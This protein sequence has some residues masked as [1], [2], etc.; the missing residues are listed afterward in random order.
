MNLCWKL[1][2]NKVLFYLLQTFLHFFSHARRSDRH[3]EA[4]SLG[5]LKSNDDHGAGRRS[6]WVG[7]FVPPLPVQQ[8]YQLWHRAPPLLVHQQQPHLIG[9]TENK[10]SHIWLAEQRAK[11]ATSNWQNREQ[12]PSFNAAGGWGADS[13]SCVLDKSFLCVTVPNICRNKYCKS[14]KRFC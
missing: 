3:R 2:P 4:D 12:I 6:R 1:Q 5:C 11:T 13:Y 10:N 7:Q 14:S 9:G 8:F